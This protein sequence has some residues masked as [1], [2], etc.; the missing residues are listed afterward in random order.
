LG[1]RFNLK[2]VALTRGG[3]G[4]LLWAEGTWSEH[5]GLAVEVCDTS[6][7]GDAL[8]AALT[9]GLLASWNLDQ[10]NDRANEVAA[11]VCTKPGG[12]PV[13]PARMMILPR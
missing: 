4:S 12:M 1:R 8:T 9:I 3:S 2:V 6:G 10:I 11:F 5:P 7:A 13:L